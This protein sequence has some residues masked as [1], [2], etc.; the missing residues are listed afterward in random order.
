MKTTGWRSPPP[1]RPDALR[2]AGACPRRTITP[3]RVVPRAPA[4]PPNGRFCRPRNLT[5]ERERGESR[6]SVWWL[7]RG[8]ERGGARIDTSPSEREDVGVDAL[9]VGGVKA[10]PRAVVDDQPAAGYERRGL[11][12]GE[13]DRG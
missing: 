2:R 3:E 1:N 8:S 9:V 6:W 5:A 4:R 11:L 12:A 13:F 10:V 7:C